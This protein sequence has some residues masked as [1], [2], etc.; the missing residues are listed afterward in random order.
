MPKN[1]ILLAF[2]T[3][4]VVVIVFAL[5]KFNI[6]VINVAVPLTSTHKVTLQTDFTGAKV[7]QEEILQGCFGQDCIPSICLLYT[8]PSPRD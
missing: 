7:K 2:L 1:I 8:S 3:I 5:S 4:F 6:N